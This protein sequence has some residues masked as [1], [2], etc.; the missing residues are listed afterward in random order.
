M[1]TYELHTVKGLPKPER[2]CV[3]RTVQPDT[4]FTYPQWVRHHRLANKKRF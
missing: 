4:R 2:K 3:A 1:K